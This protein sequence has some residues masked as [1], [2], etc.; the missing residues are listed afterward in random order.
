M[1]NS[2]LRGHLNLKAE[3]GLL[4][5]K[6]LEKTKKKYN[7]FQSNPGTEVGPIGPIHFGS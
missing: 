3:K 4:K 6:V 5:R 7:C 1:Q 2:I